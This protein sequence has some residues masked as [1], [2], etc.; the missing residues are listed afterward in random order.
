MKRLS[1]L[2]LCAPLLVMH[3]ARASPNAAPNE[4]EVGEVEAGVVAGLV[5][6]EVCVGKFPEFAGRL[7]AW[8]TEP[9][10]GVDWP[11]MVRIIKL[12]PAYQKASAAMQLQKVP[13]V[14]VTDAEF[15]AACV[16]EFDESAKRRASDRAK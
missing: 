8:E 15:R 7:A 1:Y 3:A 16:S 12:R 10:P 4:D 2:V 9:R 13:V 14:P 11:E 5:T 6:G